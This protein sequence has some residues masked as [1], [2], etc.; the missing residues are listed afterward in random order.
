MTPKVINRYLKGRVVYVGILFV[1]SWIVRRF[2]SRDGACNLGVSNLCKCARAC[3]CPQNNFVVVQ[4]REFVVINIRGIN[5]RNALLHSNNRYY[6][7]L[8]ARYVCAFLQVNQWLCASSW[9][10]S[11]QDFS[12][13]QRRCQIHILYRICIL[14]IHFDLLCISQNA[15]SPFGS[16][17]KTIARCVWM[18]WLVSN[19]H[20]YP[21]AGSWD[22]MFGIVSYFFPLLQ[23]NQPAT[24]EY[25][26]EWQRGV[27]FRWICKLA[28]WWGRFDHSSLQQK[29]GGAM[30]C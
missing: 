4:N 7:R 30:G 3:L 1:V 28:P 13:K 9:D 23:A 21:K 12:R 8:R 19:I 14:F 11:A 10:M 16:R 6:I 27:R 18:R 15:R 25:H 2:V 5:G 24:R 20:I 26:I 22:N 17:I 29:R